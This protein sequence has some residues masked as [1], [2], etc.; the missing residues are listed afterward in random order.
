[1]ANNT[2]MNH[3]AERIALTRAI[4]H[5]ASETAA[6][7]GRTTFN[8][9]VIRAIA[10]VPRHLFIPGAPPPGVAYANRPQPI[11]LG[12]TISQPYI[13][14]LMTELLDLDG[15]E[16]VLE[17]GTGSGYQTAVLAEIAGEVYSVERFADLAAGARATLAECGYSNIH[18]SCSD[19]TRGWVE[20]APYDAIM[21]TA[22]ADGPVPQALI[23]QLQPGGRMVIPLGP[24]HGPQMLTVGLKDQ[25]GRFTKHPVL[26]VSFV[27]LV[28]LGKEG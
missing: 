21:V 12:Q 19:G 27:P 14:A 22:A 8:A 18:M 15:G 28:S 20:H 9:R 24:R 5:E 10:E 13:V 23:E 7:T 2:E 11:G 16:K 4:E 26:P 6:W 25:T 17:V 1:M 3:K